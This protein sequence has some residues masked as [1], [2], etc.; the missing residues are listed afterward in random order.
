MEAP[1]GGFSTPI[2]I[3]AKAGIHEYGAARTLPS[4]LFMEFGLG[5][6]DGRNDGSA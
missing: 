4:P 3:P 1:S 6:D 5:R 2:V